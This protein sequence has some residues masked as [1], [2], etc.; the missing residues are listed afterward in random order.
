MV[1]ISQLVICGTRSGIVK[2]VYGRA[3]IM[4]ESIIE[5]GS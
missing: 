5:V 2:K 4:G 1:L 3:C